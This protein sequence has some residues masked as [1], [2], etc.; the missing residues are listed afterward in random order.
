MLGKYRTG[1][2]PF[3]TVYLHGLVTAK[4]GKKMSKSK[5]NVISPLELSDK[6]GTDALRMGLIIGNTPGTTTALYE[7]KIKAYKLFCNKIWNVTRFVLENTEGIDPAS[8]PTLE[9]DKMLIEELQSITKDVTADI[10]GY[11]FYMAGEKLYHYVWHRF[12]DQILEESKPILKAG[13]VEEMASRKAALLAILKTSLTLLHP[14]M[15][16]VTEEI[17]KDVPGEKASLLMIEKWP[18]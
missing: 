5:G 16:Y 9:K 2:L 3:S 1:N 10:E 13:S 15:P 6:Y 18:S 7:E 12:A 4:D 17:W 11:R 14:F 8:T